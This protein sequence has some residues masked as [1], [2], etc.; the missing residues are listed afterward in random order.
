M[1]QVIVCMYMYYICMYLNVTATCKTNVNFQRFSTTDLHQ[2]TTGTP[3]EW[4]PSFCNSHMYINI[5]MYV[6]LYKYIP[7]FQDAHPLCH[8]QHG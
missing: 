1:A 7:S 8:N 4:F 3:S 5:C 6:N 2:F